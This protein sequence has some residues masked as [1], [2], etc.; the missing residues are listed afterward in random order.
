[1]AIIKAG[2]TFSKAS[3]LGISILVFRSGVCFLLVSLVDSSRFPRCFL[4]LH[5]TKN[6]QLT[7]GPPMGLPPATKP[8][9]RR[10]KKMV[11]DIPTSKTYGS[12]VL[13]NFRRPDFGAEKTVGKSLC[14]FCG[15]LVW[16]DVWSNYSDLT[17]PHPKWW[18]SKG[19]PLVS[20]NSRLVKYC[21]WRL[22]R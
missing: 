9:R 11:K 13:V 19:N 15:T 14:V 16:S 2:A 3:F 10:S 18:F 8:A 7:H 22:S 12:G 5:Q 6:L 21:I 17:R 20:G 4:Y 1:M